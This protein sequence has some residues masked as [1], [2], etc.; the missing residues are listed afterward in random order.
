MRVDERMTKNVKCCSAGDS[1]AEAA[2]LLWEH[3]C[4]CA[5]VVDGNG[6]LQGILTDRD[7]CMA[8]YTTGRGLHELHVADIMA[9]NIATARP[10]ESL[11]QAEMIMRA[12]GVRRLPVVNEQHRVVGMLSC[13]DLCR[14]VDDGGSNGSQHHDAVHLVGTLATV[15][16]PRAAAKADTD[17][18]GPP[19]PPPPLV[20]EPRASAGSHTPLTPGKHGRLP[21]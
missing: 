3:D 17:A 4:G 8:A 19:A 15:G 7:I 20:S 12:R 1:L 13:N 5:P 11:Q 2:R 9:R 21:R 6:R 18:Q 14:W 16:R 10:Q